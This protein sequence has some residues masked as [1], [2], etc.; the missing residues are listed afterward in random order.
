MFECTVCSLLNIF[1]RSNRKVL[2]RTMILDI[3]RTKE[4]ILF[5]GTFMCRC[6]LIITSVTQAF[7]TLELHFQSGDSSDIVCS[8]MEKLLGALASCASFNGCSACGSL[9]ASNKW[10]GRSFLLSNVWW[11]RN[12][13]GSRRMEEAW[14]LWWSRWWKPWRSF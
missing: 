4:Q 2:V 3:G 5:I 13:G 10:H 11:K 8:M 14:W 6:K 1:Y 7:F 9:V 12:R